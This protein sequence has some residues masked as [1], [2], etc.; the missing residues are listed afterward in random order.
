M[1][2]LRQGGLGVAFFSSGAQMNLSYT[3]ENNTLKVKQNSP[4]MERFYYPLPY[5]IAQQLSIE[6]EPMRWEMLLYSGGTQLKGKKISTEARVEGE[7]L[8][9]LRPGTASESIWV[10]P[11]QRPDGR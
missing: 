7:T 9:E 5:I 8:V 6:A 2:R 4:N 1:I 10:R 3:I 11:G